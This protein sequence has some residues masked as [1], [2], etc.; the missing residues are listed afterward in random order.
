VYFRSCYEK[1]K[2]IQIEFCFTN[3]GTLWVS[4][5]SQGYIP[6]NDETKQKKI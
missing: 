3:A 6:L 4:S 2:V 1:L 5:I